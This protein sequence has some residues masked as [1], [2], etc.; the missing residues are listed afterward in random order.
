MISIFISGRNQETII[1]F[2]TVW[3]NRASKRIRLVPYGQ[4]HRLRRLEPGLFVFADIDRITPPQQ[5]MV[6]E[7]QRQLTTCFGDESILNLPSGVLQRFDL[8][9]TV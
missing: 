8:L 2:L 7:L 5:S 6:E 3:S 4:I 1:P 9:T